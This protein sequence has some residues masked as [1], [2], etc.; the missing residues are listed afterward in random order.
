MS[1]L[2]DKAV[3]TPIDLSKLPF[4]GAVETLDYEAIVSDMLVDLR[5]RAPQFTAT[6]ESDPAYKLIEVFAYR[7]LVL[8]QRINDAVKAVMIPF[9]QGADLDNLVALLG[10][11]RLVDETDE[12]LRFRA[13]LALE[14]YSVAGPVGAYTFFGLSAS[15]LVKD[16]DVASPSPGEV[17][18][19]VLSTE[20]D[21]APA[22]ALVAE[23]HDYLNADERRPLTDHLTTQG[24]TVIPYTVDAT[25]YLY[26]GPD[27]EEVR[28]LAESQVTQYTLDHHRLGHDISLSG[29]HRAL[30]IEGAVQRVEIATPAGGLVV[31]PSESA[32]ATAIS[33]VI[34]G[35]DE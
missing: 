32:Y 18:I 29:L 8:R 24:A 3:A 13:Q 33:V 15:N 21:G 4:P 2:N 26:R 23:V 22:P 11:E 14:G 9:A 10:V 35:I 25:L 19:T 34:G 31:A 6:V 17:V 30:H 7:E 1:V 28:A 12:R 20:G 27:A 16:I 5:T